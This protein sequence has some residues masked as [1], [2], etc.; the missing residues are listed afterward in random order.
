[1]I[2]PRARRRAIASDVYDHTSVLKMIEW[3]HGLQPLT[4]RDAAAR[5]LAEV[6]DFD[7]KPNL[8]APR[9]NVPRP[10][11]LGCLKATEAPI[12]G[13]VPSPGAHVHHGD[14]WYH[15]AD[16]AHRNRFGH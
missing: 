3:R 14:D 15:L 8:H 6:L 10:L 9:Y 2:S 5:N 16:Y 7:R 1:V 11:S 13:T 4:V 12:P